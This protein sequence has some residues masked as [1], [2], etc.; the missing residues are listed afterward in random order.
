MKVEM[1]GPENV[2]ASV[3]AGG[4]DLLPHQTD[5]RQPVA[6]RAL[7]VFVQSQRD[8]LRRPGGQVLQM[9]PEAR[10]DAVHPVRSERRAEK[11]PQW[12]VGGAAP[13]LQRRGRLEI[14]A[15]IPKSPAVSCCL[16]I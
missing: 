6:L 9:H 8:V 3:F 16:I 5:L 12:A 4:K 13:S 1:M 14:V 10:P 11:H 7:E 2:T 15:E